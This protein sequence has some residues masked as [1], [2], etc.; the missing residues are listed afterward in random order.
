MR[1]PN[2]GYEPRDR[3]LHKPCP[4]PACGHVWVD[5]ESYVT[6]LCDPISDIQTV[7]DI[8]CGLKGMIGQHYWENVRH[9]P[10]GYACDIHVLKQLPASPPCPT[11][12]V[13]LQVDAEDLLAPRL[14][15]PRS[16]DVVTHCGML[17]HVDYVKAFR[18][19]RV[20]EQVAKQLVFFT[21]SAVCREV[22]Y[23]V[24]RDGNPYHYYRSF[25]DGDIFEALG[26]T[27]DRAR[28]I[29]GETFLE[30]V[31]CWY[32]PESLGPWAPRAATASRLLRVRH[33][34]AP[35]CECEPVWWDPRLNGGR[36]GSLCFRHAEERSAVQSHGG[37]PIKQWYDDPRKLEKFPYPPGRDKR[38]LFAEDR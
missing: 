18:I 14:L 4:N 16:V 31:T 24:Q 22:D 17:E 36:G 9:V 11:R 21:C 15:G 29:S 32:D 27:V 3:L 23:K 10:L 1:C 34:N 7:L 26:Y 30:E 2:C 20:I 8:G 25:W 19:L 12:W 33:C 37:A 6:I 35:R 13:P 5:S 38:P 28:M